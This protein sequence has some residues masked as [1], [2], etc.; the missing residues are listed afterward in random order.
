MRFP[1]IL[2]RVLLVAGACCLFAACQ[3]EDAG[4]SQTE[5]GTLVLG[6]IEQTAL[7]ERGVLLAG[8]TLVLDG[9]RGT[10]ALEGTDDAVARFVFTMTA[11]GRTAETAAEALD[12]ITLEESGDG[13][14]Y[15]YVMRSEDPNL[16]QVRINGAVPRGAA[17]RLRLASGNV[18]LSGVE[19]ALDIRLDD[20]GI[21]VAGAA[22]A[23]EAQTRNGAVEVGM[24][25]VPA[26][27]AL[28]VQTTNGSITLT[29]PGTSAAAVEAQT[30]AGTI[31]TTDLD[32]ADRRLDPEGA[33]ARFRGRLGT[34]GA[35]ITLRTENGTI[36]LREGTVRSL[37]PILP[38]PDST[39][40]PLAPPAAAPDSSVA[41]PDTLP[42]PLRPPPGLPGDSTRASSQRA[43]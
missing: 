27:G 41:P 13:E 12:G 17:V 40:A 19:G 31:T 16:S 14:V 42:M 38:M 39:A 11:R 3:P 8:R 28:R 30:S 5:E 18:E 36:A 1:L 23:V 37:A 9:F 4:V 32:F 29:V 10:I 43:I 6:E 7:A 33:G 26:S 22:D 25:R 20:G 21:R 15:R 2:R 35:A 24:L 34:G